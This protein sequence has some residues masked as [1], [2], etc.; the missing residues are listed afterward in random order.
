M[1]KEKKYFL[2]DIGYNVHFRALV[3]WVKLV[4]RDGCVSIPIH[5]Q[6]GLGFFPP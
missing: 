3:N 5:I 1:Q 4:V 6:V 2:T